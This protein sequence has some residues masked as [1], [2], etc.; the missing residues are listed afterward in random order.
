MI[1]VRLS[2][3]VINNAV[4]SPNQYGFRNNSSTEKATFKLLNDILQ[5]LN[6]KVYVA[7]IFCD[8]EKAFDCVSHD[9]LM[10]NLI[11]NTTL[12]CQ[13]QCIGRLNLLLLGSEGYLM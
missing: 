6:N 10:K 1:Y 13:H 9:L 12:R 4:L 8:F 11:I 3:H 5:T 2:K 7:G